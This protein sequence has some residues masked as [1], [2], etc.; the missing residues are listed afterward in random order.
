VHLCRDAHEWMRIY[1]IFSKKRKFSPYFYPQIIISS[2]YTYIFK[3]AQLRAKKSPA[4]ET[5]GP[6]YEKN[7]AYVGLN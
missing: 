2:A 3:F 1:I 7:L 6:P 4:V 5:T